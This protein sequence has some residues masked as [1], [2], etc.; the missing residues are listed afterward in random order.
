MG[1]NSQ[2]CGCWEV[3]QL[4][5]DAGADK[6]EAYSDSQSDRERERERARVTPRGLDRPPCPGEERERES[7]FGVWLPWTLTSSS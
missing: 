5:L 6:D 4:L 7:S 1:K 3:V 2:P